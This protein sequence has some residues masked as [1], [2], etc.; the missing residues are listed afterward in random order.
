MITK[1]EKIEIFENTVSSLRKK[2]ITDKER[3]DEQDLENNL[4]AEKYRRLP[5]D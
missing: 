4:L 5:L 1:E 3:L 2:F